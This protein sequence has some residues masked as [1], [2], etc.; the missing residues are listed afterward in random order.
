MSVSFSSNLMHERT[1]LICIGRENAPLP[2]RSSCCIPQ[3]EWQALVGQPTQA[4]ALAVQIC[5]GLLEVLAFVFSQQHC[6]FV[7]NYHCVRSLSCLQRPA[8]VGTAFLGSI[9][10]GVPLQR[11]WENVHTPPD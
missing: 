11:I 2:P 8:A 4:D 5:K 1:C 3:Q 10:V 6:A 9:P 7:N